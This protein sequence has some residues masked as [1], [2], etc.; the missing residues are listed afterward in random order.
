MTILPLAI[1]NYK[2][3]NCDILLLMNEQK[4]SI[5]SIANELGLSVSTVS[6][7]LNGIGKKHRIS[8]RTIEAVESMAEELDYEPN[9][10]AKS[11]RLKKT[12]TIGLILPDISNPW[13][14]KIALNIE[15]ELRKKH[16][17]VFLYNSNGELEIEEMAIK[18]LKN[19]NVD[20]IILAPIGVESKHILKAFKKTTPIVL[21]DRF[22]ENEE[23]PYVSTN[24]EEGAFQ[25]V[26]FIIEN[27]HSRIACFQGIQETSVNIQRVG[28][29]KRAL[30]RH[31]IM[32]DKN[33]IVGS[34]FD[35]ENGYLETKKIE[36][37]IKGKKI[38]AIFSTGNLITLGI[39]K[40][41]KELSVKVPE[42]LSLVSFDEQNY[43]ELLYTPL[44]TISHS[45]EK[46]G[47]LAVD[48]LFDQIDKRVIRDS[49]LLPTQLI[50]R[51]S[52]KKMN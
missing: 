18:L 29:Y 1:P 10:I 42:D 22:F 5:K 7:V 31:E 20:G 47:S 50:I 41:L 43:S 33:L 51:K 15:K 12:S 34:G 27:G 13:F 48:L 25:A 30:E 45:D 36:N 3:L 37:E 44:T 32:V 21:I 9:N 23:I 6:R 17:N 8:Q 14:A 52:V 46:I 16:Y 4:S 39:M 2:I 24:D 40:A 49:V 19:W 28:G 11:L 35:I 38:T 26:N